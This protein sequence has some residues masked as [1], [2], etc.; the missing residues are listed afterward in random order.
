MKTCSNCHEEKDESCFR[1]RAESKDGLNGYCKQCVTERVKQWR[2]NNPDKDKKN[3]QEWAAN[4]L[5]KNNDLKK[6]WAD[7]NP[8]KV[9]ESREKW[10]AANPDK[11]KEVRKNSNTKT[12]STVKGRLSSRISK[13]MNDYLRRGVKGRRHWESLLDYSVEELVRHLETRFLPGMSW[14]NMGKWHIDHILPQSHFYYE[15]P[16]DK[17]FKACWALNN[18]QPLWAK[19]NLRKGDRL[20][21]ER[22]Y[23][24]RENAK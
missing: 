1:K 24:R 2:I 22:E 19:D 21:W 6:S 16:E 14:D 4:N 8:E 17:D 20:P 18:L 13:L 12:R 7:S 15:A 3:R 23:L 10:I 5:E 11:I 9:R